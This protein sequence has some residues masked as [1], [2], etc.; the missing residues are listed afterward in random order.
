MLRRLSSRATVCRLTRWMVHHG[1]R[2]LQHARPAACHCQGPRDVSAHPPQGPNKRPEVPVEP[3]GQLTTLDPRALAWALPSCQQRSS[4]R[5]LPVKVPLPL[6][7]PCSRK[8]AGSQGGRAPGRRSEGSRGCQA[9]RVPVKWDS[10][11]LQ[12]LLTGPAP[13]GPVAIGPFR[14]TCFSQGP[15]SF[16]LRALSARRETRGGPLDPVTAFVNRTGLGLVA[17]GRGALGGLT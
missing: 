7:T 2:A 17:E 8:A 3:A 15:W 10:C 4:P 1:G 5:P 12:C 16:L 13:R 9:A 14:F 11:Y 6:C